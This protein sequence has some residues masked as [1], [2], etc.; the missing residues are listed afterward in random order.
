MGSSVP[1]VQCTSAKNDQC[2]HALQ[3]M[4][5]SSDSASTAVDLTSVTAQPAHATAN[6]NAPASF[7]TYAKTTSNDV[8]MPAE[9]MHENDLPPLKRRS[10]WRCTIPISSHIG[11]SGND[12]WMKLRPAT[13][14]LRIHRVSAT[15]IVIG[16]RDQ[17]EL[18]AQDLQDNP[19]T[20][21]NGQVQVQK[22]R[23]LNAWRRS[24]LLLV[25]SKAKRQELLLSRWC[26]DSTLNLVT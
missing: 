14:A 4:P 25:S 2:R 13:F 24:L 15:Q 7:D 23:L 19:E 18:E 11:H 3:P 6:F 20:S 17:E 16:D 1:Q 10:E 12:I 8:V 22:K 21:T 5:P 26:Y 9:T